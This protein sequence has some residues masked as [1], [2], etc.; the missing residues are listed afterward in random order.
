VNDYGDDYVGRSAFL[1]IRSRRRRRPPVSLSHIAF[2]GGCWLLL[3]VQIAGAG[4]IGRTIRIEN[5]T[6]P[7]MDWQEIEVFG[8]AA[9][10]PDGP[11]PNL[12]RDKPDILSGSGGH[13][14]AKVVDG[15][16]DPAERG[17]GFRREGDPAP[18]GPWVEIDLGEPT[19]IARIVLYG[20]RYPQKIY[21]DKGHR[22]LSVLDEERRVVWIERFD[23]YDRRF[24]KDGI[25]AFEP[26]PMQGALIGAQLAPDAAEWLPLSWVLEVGEEPLPPDAEQRMARFRTRQSPVVVE[27]LAHRFFRLLEPDAPG[28][29]EARQLYAAGQYADALESWKQYWFTKMQRVNSRS[30]YDAF[31]FNYTS[32]GEDLMAGVRV[33]ISLHTIRATR[34][35][36]GRIKWVDLPNPND[37][38]A[39]RNALGD[40]GQLA[41]VNKVPR[42]LIKSFRAEGD[43]KVVARWAEIMDD[44][45]LNFFADADASPHNIKDLFVMIPANHWGVMMEELADI[46]AE[47]P[48]LVDLIP[49]DTLTRIQLTCIEQ[50]GPAYWRQAR[51]TVFNHNT[52]AL[53]AWGKIL[54]YIDEFRPGQRIAREWRQHFE[55]WMTQGTLR[56]GSMVEIGDEGHFGIPMILGVPLAE[57]DSAR[58]DWYTPGW[59]NR[60]M[61]YYDNLHK[62]VFRHP[63]PGGYDHRFNFRYTWPRWVNLTDPY[64]RDVR[65]GVPMLDRSEVIYA[66]PEVRR[67]I[68][69]LCHVSAG[70][71]VVDK[72]TPW[73]IQRVIKPKQEAYDAALEVL[74][75]ERP[76]TPHL[77]SDWMPY[78]G[79]YYLRGGWQEGDAFLA[80]LARGANTG[81]EPIKPSFGLVYHHDYN[82]P[83]FRAEAPTI[84][85]QWQNPL[86][87]RNTW[88]PGTKTSNLT[89]A[90]RD[91]APFRWHTS[92]HFDYG[93][94]VYEGAYQN[95][96]FNWQY[97]EYG[98]IETGGDPITDVR[99]ARQVLH[100]RD[101]RLFIV[102]DSV[103][104]DGAAQQASEH[105]FSIPCQLA[106]S[107]QKEGATKP[108]SIEQL[109]LDSAA[110]QIRT[111]NPDGANVTVHQFTEGPIEYKLGREAKPDFVKYAQRLSEYTGIAEQD[112][113][114]D[115]KAGGDLALV[116]LIAS[117]PQGGASRVKTIEPMNRGQEIAGF[118]ATLVDGTEIWYQAAAR[119]DAEL[120][121]GPVSAMAETL[122]VVSDQS[123]VISGVVLGCEDLRTNGKPIEIPC[124]DFEFISNF[125]FSIFNFQSI[126]RPIAPV[127]FAPD[128][129]VFTDT[130]TVT[131]AS[132][133]PG[134]EIRYTT[135]GSSPTRASPLYTGPIT[136]SATTEIA[137]RAY[138]LGPDGKPLPAD[139]FEINGTRFT[140]PSYGWF[141]KKALKP[142]AT[143]NEGELEPGLNYDYLQGH[144]TRLFNEAHWMPAAGGGTAEREMDLSKVYT[145]DHYGMRYKGYLRVPEDGV[146][147]FHAPR[148]FVYADNATSYDMRMYID[149]EQWYLTQWW[150][151]LGTW[152][153]PLKKGFHSFQLDFVDARTDPYRKSGMWRWYPRPWVVYQ[154][155]P[156][157]ILLSGPGMEKQRIPKGWFFRQPV[158]RTFPDERR[159]PETGQLYHNSEAHRQALRQRDEERYRERVRNAGLR[160]DGSKPFEACGL[161]PGKVRWDQREPI[162]EA[163]LVTVDGRSA[164]SLGPM[165]SYTYTMRDLAHELAAAN[166]YVFECRSRLDRNAVLGL[167]LFGEHTRWVANLRRDRNGE[168]GL[169]YHDGQHRHH[170]VGDGFHDLR[171]VVTPDPWRVTVDIDGKTVAEDS[172]MHKMNSV[173]PAV[174]WQNT[175]EDAEVR[176][177]IASL[178]V[179]SRKAANG[180]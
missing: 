16:K 78:T 59:R 118:H 79:S 50:Y 139:A 179:Q 128:R 175:A 65:R 21:L 13:W 123:S 119:G 138:R 127:R 165:T 141:Y 173:T 158:A 98:R 19:D 117:R 92:D 122:A 120:T 146:Y 8:G 109:E 9:P 114:A 160:V 112:V 85:G 89:Y 168:P 7:H 97:G 68:D 82:A 167:V 147:T 84:D 144:W 40:T 124:A 126:L 66:I 39:F 1:V 166:G 148:E 150:H 54:P 163:E 130:L 172:P 53:F 10:G 180:E 113:S 57:L 131:M 74:G 28:L 152:S 48:E 159:D 111:A 25:F 86:Y 51:K 12:V 52:S 153:V 58:P 31:A 176:V 37:V 95:L 23:Y 99:S 30:A 35:T 102:T 169:G 69:T 64:H 83:L 156:S 96:V 104:F 93:E 4:V 94:A 18:I 80:M 11:V 91:P 32:Q 88:M 149:G 162:T 108:F 157:D 14:M 151:G 24:Y 101:S 20:S 110:K 115:L 2:V 47:R 77:N 76:G 107:T 145:H 33:A 116:S 177:L 100:L 135:D 75:D 44:W 26:Q 60:A 42:G 137:A 73:W 72:E 155:K 87:G 103:H 161:Y 129:N 134:V 34:F 140:V 70:R 55:R 6:A 29:G 38:T 61:E 45:C 36:P 170:P 143:V 46:A 43:P 171:F 132:A 15:H 81:S 174:Q 41:L 121:C 27:A 63:S 178:T 142:A 154:G 164:L 106:L 56:D 133:T 5:P 71:P 90:Q 62:Y 67:I 105:T 22:V 3:L 49:A 17:A 136:I 125:Q